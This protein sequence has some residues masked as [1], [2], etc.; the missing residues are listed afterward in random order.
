MRRSRHLL[1][2][3][4]APALLLVA[5]LDRCPEEGGLVSEADY[6][7]RALAYLEFAT[8]AQTGS[9]VNAIA[10]MERDRVD[11]AYT[12]PV[13][14]VDENTWAGSWEKLDKLLDTRDFDGLY[15][16]T[17]LLG[18]EGHPYLTEA[19]WER[20]RQGLLSF[21]MW[22]TDPT[23]ALPD[24]DDPDCQDPPDT[25]HPDSDGLC[26]D[27]DES[28]YWTENHQILYHTIE[29]LAGQRFPDACFWIV[30]FERTD[31][32]SGPG[33]ATGAEHMARARPKIE[34]WLDERWESGFAEWHSLVYYQ[35][36]A[37]PLLA[38]VEFAEDEEIAARAAMI[39]DLL[40][41]DLATHTYRGMVAA[42][43]G[44]SDMKDKHR[45]P[46]NDTWGLVLLTLDP[47]AELGYASTGDAGA[48]LFARAKKYRPPKVAVEAARSQQTFVDL[49]RMSYAL[50]ERGPVVPDPV[51]P[52]GHGFSDT[53]ANFTFWW[54]LGAWTAWQV[55]PLTLVNAYRYNMWNMALLRPFQPLRDLVGNPPNILGGQNLAA[56]LWPLAA[57]GLLKEVN[58][59]TY[60]T[61]DY[62]L[63]SAQDYR[64][65]ANAGQ[66]Q[67]W[68]AT[69]GP[70]AV[71][72]T[73]H[74]MVP[75]VPPSGWLGTPDGQPGYWS[76][77][78]SMPRSAQFENVAI[79]I[80][81]PAYPDGG[82]PGLGLFDY[83]PETHAYFPQDH[84]D[85]LVRA[86]RWTFGNYRD[87]AYIA[88]YSYWIPGWR[89]YPAEEMALLPHSPNG[90]VQNPFDLVAVSPLAPPE[91]PRR[92]DD[93]WLVECARASDWES[94]EAFQAA[95][96]AA[97]LQ[98]TRGTNNAIQYDV[99]YDS[100]SQGEISFGWNA[101]FTVRGE[102]VPLDGY[103]RMQNP[104][105]RAPRGAPFVWLSGKDSGLVLDWAGGTRNPYAF[106]G[107]GA[108]PA[109]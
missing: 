29:Y 4:L 71:V 35:K 44:R 47:D 52:P 72:F 74:P 31:D 27:W 25:T 104:W 62:A 7:A 68:Q 89:E 5:T 64:K 91:F 86:G 76:G 54:G 66:V 24:P 21:K 41:M 23:P 101:P 67:A 14:V 94:F 37:T 11:P 90:P 69:F 82:A 84:F 30:G 96:Q 102:T 43:H 73:T 95:I 55:V 85:E 34:R 81:N 16:L 50:D 6:H 32:C 100:P 80:Y 8:S 63:S 92:A 48:G 70:E 59:Y 45:G 93:L 60:R 18:Y 20:V 97:D 105:V 10:H 51:H 46:A 53:E 78:A 61:P 103:P 12:A 17:A 9:I 99:V 28:F 1:L 87:R 36:D 19:A 49:Q 39:L 13:G 65:G 2:L 56:T 83:E 38:L 75:P 3:L 77:T 57:V 109:E 107:A 26:R 33:E 42:T 22:Y 40:L 108:A 106:F 79:H 88:L 15:L 58:T 98:V